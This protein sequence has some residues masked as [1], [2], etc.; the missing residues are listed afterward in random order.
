MKQAR[1]GKTVSHDLTHGCNLKSLNNS[2]AGCG[3]WEGEEEERWIGAYRVADRV[4]L[5]GLELV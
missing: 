2:S 4:S 1:H 5:T 3:G